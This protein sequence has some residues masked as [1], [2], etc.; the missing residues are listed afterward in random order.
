MRYLPCPWL[1]VAPLALVVLGLSSGC[2]V[3]DTPTNN[4]H[5]AGPDMPGQGNVDLSVP[6]MYRAPGSLG[7]ACKKDNDCNQGKSP[8]CWADN[9]G[10]Q[11]GNLPALNG[12][13]TSQCSNDDDCG[14]QGICSTVVQGQPKYCLATCSDANTCRL[15]DNFACF[16]NG[17]SGGY[18]WPTTK[19][20]CNPTLNQGKCLDRSPVQACVRRTYEDLG[21]CRTICDFGPMACKPLPRGGPDSGQHCIQLN[22]TRDPQGT[23]TRDLYNGP[24]CLTLLDKPRGDG[25]G[26]EFYDECADNYECNISPG[27]DSKCHLICVVGV[28]GGC[29]SGLK[30]KDVFGAGAGKGGLCLSQ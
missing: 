17:P 1:T 19:L 7:T 14:G 26:C 5:D 12:Y 6:D 29:D 20:G 24:V 10:D 23:P 3:A 15:A 30:C 28:T 27:G 22:S 21:E 16:L 13:C 4:K 18:C 11:P 8:H 2:T 9:I 25:A